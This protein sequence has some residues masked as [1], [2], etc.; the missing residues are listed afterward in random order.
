MLLALAVAT[1]PDALGEYEAPEPEAAAEIDSAV[2]TPTITVTGLEGRLEENFRAFMDVASEACD[3]PADRVRRR[4]ARLEDNL[5][6]ALRPFGYYRAR[7]LRDDL[8]FEEECWSLSVDVEAG[9]RVTVAQVD[10]VLEGDAEEDTV[11]TDLIG[12]LPIRPGEPLEHANYEGAK[13]AIQSLAA[14]RGY[15]EGRFKTSELRVD[16]NEGRADVFLHFNSGPR[17]HIGDVTIEQSVLDPDFVDRLA[18]IESGIP[19][20]GSAIAELYRS[21]E[22]SGYFSRVAVRPRVDRAEG[23]L[24]PIEVTTEPR[25]RKSFEIGLGVE[26]DTGPRITFNHANRR[27]NPKGHRFNT[28]LKLSTAESI[29]DANYRIPLSK[30]LKEHL[31]IYGGAKYEDSDNVLTR[32]GKIGVSRSLLRGNGWLRTYALDLTREESE[33]GDQDIRATM[34]T[35]AVSWSKTTADNRIRPT[36]GYRLFLRGLVGSEAVLS[37]TDIFQLHGRAKW[38]RTVPGGGRLIVRG[39]LGATL[40]GEFNV[41][42]AGFRFYAGGD[43]SVR[44]YEYQSLAPEDEDGNVLGGERLAVGSIEYEHPLHR[45]WGGALF[46]DTGDAFMEEDPDFRTGVGIGLRW[47]S[48]VGPIKVDLAHPMDDPDTDVRVHFSM[49]VEL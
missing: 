11:F 47:Y 49:G 45:N 12:E 10:V 26:T 38:I 9:E 34:L 44:G 4:S 20:T 13:S 3:S 7:L 46:V 15:F 31:N 39:E 42:P 25:K 28:G 24:V 17:F 18:K 19:Y 29:L 8:R 48:R 37:E 27:V 33:I 21:L 30:P 2:T 22:D 6:K 5:D 41:L 1:S 14:D 23:H 35:P 32:G 16:P 40:A 36:R 43:N